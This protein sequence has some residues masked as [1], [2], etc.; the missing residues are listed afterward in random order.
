[1]QKKEA[2][3]SSQTLSSRSGG[4]N[5]LNHDADSARSKKILYDCDRRAGQITVRHGSPREGGN[6][7]SPLSKL[8]RPRQSVVFAWELATDANLAVATNMVMVRG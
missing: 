7:Q 6:V 2:K 3:I 1:M 8:K 5:I 4:Y